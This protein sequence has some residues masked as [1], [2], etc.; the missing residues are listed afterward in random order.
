[1]Y[2]LINRHIDRLLESLKLDRHV[3]P[4][5]S[6]C[7]QLQ[8]TNVATD[9]LFQSQYRNYWAMNPARLSPDFITAYFELLETKKA[10]TAVTVEEVAHNLFR[11][12]SHGKGRQTLQFSFASKLVHM[13]QSDRPIYDRMVERFFFLPL[14]GMARRWTTS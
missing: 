4:Y 10:E 2:S 11:I 6:L 14:R 8:K 3:G 5:L 9:L 12:P 7:A 1:M 13:I